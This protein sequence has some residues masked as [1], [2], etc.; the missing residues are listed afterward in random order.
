MAQMR[1]PELQ[2]LYL[3]ARFSP[4][5]HRLR[6][7]NA[8]DAVLRLIQPGKSY[9]WEFLCFHLTGYRPRTRDAT[10]LI[11]YNTLLHDLSVYSERISRTLRILIGEYANQKIHT[12]ETLC[13]RFGVCE[14]TI[15][16]WRRKGL[17]GRYA[18]FGD[19]KYRLVFPA[20]TVELFLRRQRRQVRRGKSFS[21]LTAAEK[22]DILRRL[23]R[24]G[25][26][27]PDRRQEAI[28]R[29]AR[30]FGR[31]VE[32][33]RSILVAYEKVILPRQVFAKRSGYLE[34]HQQQEAAELYEQGVSIKE[35]MRRYARSRSSVYRAINFYRGRQ[36]KEMVINYMPSEEFERAGGEEDILHPPVDLFAEDKYREPTLEQKGVLS[37]L[38]SYVAHIR[39]T[40]LLTVRQE[41]F[42]FRKYNFLKYRA[43]CLQREIDLEHPQGR[44]LNQIGGY[45]RSAEE[46]KDRLIRSNLRLVVSAARKHTRND[47]EM[48]E[49][50]SEGNMALLQAVEKFD[51][52]RGVKLSTYATW[53]IF[54][55]FASFRRDEGRRRES[56]G[57]E[58]L[59]E[60]A[61]DLRRQESQLPALEAA[62]QSLQEVMAETLE[63][64]EQVIVEEHYGLTEGAKSS[65][66]VK[67]KSLSQ[68]A[69]FLGLSKERVR[70]IELVALQKLR[71]VLT[72]EQFEFL[73]Q[74]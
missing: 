33:V 14:K 16:R 30:R 66:R 59:R 37:V 17:V 58:E 57:E 69:G 3:Q 20:G 13:K 53:A 35:L 34:G 26:V 15:S 65:G 74:S 10:K 19:G 9:P 2:Q 52:G 32:T 1:S 43:A 8:C 71:K 54:K 12:V 63:E 49:L 5:K 36:I 38:E 70:Q 40:S 48:M 39:Q 23:V 44:L 50:I 64:R 24:I 28:R 21:Q 11:D 56:L 55:R 62:R 7:I 68:I 31:S 27:L 61:S 18:L 72:A 25:Q 60:A 45:M 67:A 6:Q 29:T 4:E 22:E 51:F 42:L 47:G 73:M 46:I 41:Q